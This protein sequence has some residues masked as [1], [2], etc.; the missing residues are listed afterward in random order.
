MILDESLHLRHLESR[1]QQIIGSK[2]E[3]KGQGAKGQIVLH[4]HDLD[5]LDH[6]LSC[7]GVQE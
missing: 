7:L 6:I 5:E 4:Y 1:I 2:V 3:L